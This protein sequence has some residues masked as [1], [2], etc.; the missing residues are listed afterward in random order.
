MLIS[1]LKLINSFLNN[2]I[3]FIQIFIS[4]S[5]ITKKIKYLKL[6][7]NNNIYIKKKSILISYSSSIIQS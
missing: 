1:V 3:Y 2:M 7:T 6:D 5:N 4:K